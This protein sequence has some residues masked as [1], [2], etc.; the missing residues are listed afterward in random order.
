[1]SG[2][3]EP[4]ARGE[5]PPRSRIDRVIAPYFAEPA[6]LPVLLVLL[7]HGV[8]GVAV[9]LLDTLRGGF[10]FAAI[11]LGLT[12]VGTLASLA[13]DLRRRH[14]GVTSGSLLS[15]FVLGALLA[16]AADRYDYY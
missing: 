16:W 2:D 14:F 9:A 15:F 4:D 8:L 10:G 7:A 11:A 6:L 13:G 12:V 1:M 3:L 5:G